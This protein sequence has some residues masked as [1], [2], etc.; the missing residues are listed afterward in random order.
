MAVAFTA[1]L[2]ALHL[3]DDD[4]VTLY[5]WFHHFTHYLSAFYCGRTYCHCSVVVDE[6]HFLEL[7]RLAFFHIFHVVN[8][9]FLSLFGLELLTHDFYNCVHFLLYNRL[10]RKAYST[11][12]SLFRA[13]TE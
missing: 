2:A 8:E 6:K 5:Q 9:E 1:I 13:S 11:V 10:F 4:L 7:N 12:L 3:E